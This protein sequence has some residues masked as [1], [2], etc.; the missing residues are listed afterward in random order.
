MPSTK[1]KKID[2]ERAGLDLYGAVG[3]PSGEPAAPPP[4]RSRGARDL[5]E[6]QVETAIAD[7]PLRRALSGLGEQQRGGLAGGLR[8][9]LGGEP[10]QLPGA[11]AGP[12]AGRR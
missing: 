8:G 11:A 10:G 2:C 4:D 6:G 12:P 1:Q 3:E 5:S 9:Q 7:A